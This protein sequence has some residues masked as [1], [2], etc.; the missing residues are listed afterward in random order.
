MYAPGKAC[1]RPE[2][3]PRRQRV[4]RRGG[5]AVACCLIGDRRVLGDV[6]GGDVRRPI[7]Q[8]DGGAGHAMA[9]TTTRRTELMATLS[10]KSRAMTTKM[11]WRRRLRGRE[12][13]AATHVGVPRVR[14]L[15]PC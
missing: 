11:D 8:T 5:A 12:Q 15:R 4:A 10:V 3:G 13:S 9:W 7:D 1:S 14:R 2:S 6:L